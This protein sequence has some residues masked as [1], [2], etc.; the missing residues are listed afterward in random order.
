ME[1]SW[2][3]LQ[4][5]FARKLKIEAQ[6]I[7]D[8]TA[9]E[10]AAAEQK[11]NALTKLEESRELLATIFKEEEELK[12]AVLGKPAEIIEPA[13]EIRVPS[14]SESD[15]EAGSSL[16]A[17][18]YSF[19]L[20]RPDK[21]K[22]GQ[23]FAD[24]CEDF[25]EHIQLSKMKDDNLYIYFLGLLDSQSKK[26]L[27]KV[28]LTAAQQRSASKFIPIY[29]RKMLP[30]HE[31][32]NLKMDFSDL[33]QGKDESIEDFASRVEDVAS[34]AFAEESERTK[35]DACFS[36]FVKGL[37]DVELRVRLREGS[38]RQFQPVTDEAI[39]LFGIRTAERKR[40]A[41][42][43]SEPVPGVFPIR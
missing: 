25:K 16:G 27:R 38:I 2:S 15:G 42:T 12:S 24:F 3:T 20:S 23:S 35:D 21:Y 30:A 41:A 31:A 1:Q 19:K 29:R 34:L 5:L 37:S 40:R 14:E 4:D 17:T 26:K 43:V 8:Q 28:I 11:E 13:K 32:E 9:H 6:I 10:D 7:E 22:Q 18:S 39:R 36:A 33:T